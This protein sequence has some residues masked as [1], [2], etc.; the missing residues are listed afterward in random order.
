[1]IP[2]HLKRYH[3]LMSYYGPQ[4]WW[5]AE[6]TFEMLIGAILTQN[7]AW[8]NVDLALK[9]LKPYLSPEKMEK[10]PPEKLAECIRSSGFYRLKTR[11]IRAFLAWYKDYDYRPEKVAAENGYA[12]RKQLLAVY[13]IGKETADAMLVYAFGKPFFIADAYARRLFTR[14]GDQVPKKYEAVR[15]EV[16]RCLPDDLRVYQEYHALIDVHAKSRCKE[17][18]M[19]QGC[20][21]AEVCQASMYHSS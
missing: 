6:S 7:T 10:L 21:F 14:L 2:N 1:M 16:E 5:P 17:T 9:K 12:L 18:P 19:C 8:K 3:I 4:H 15:K 11:R 20:P 13:G